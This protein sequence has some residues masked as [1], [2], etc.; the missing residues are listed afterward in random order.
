MDGM[1]ATLCSRAYQENDR[2]VMAAHGFPTKM[3]E[4]KRVAELR[5]VQC[6]PAM[7]TGVA[8]IAVL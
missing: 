3:T 4:S 2:A 5:W 6:L 8:F 7:P 1:S